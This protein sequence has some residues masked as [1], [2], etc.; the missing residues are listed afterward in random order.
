MNYVLEK[1][2][3]SELCTTIKLLEKRE[4]LSVCCWKYFCKRI[5]T[6]VLCKWVQVA[7]VWWAGRC[8]AERADDFLLLEPWNFPTQQNWYGWLASSHTGLS[9][10]RS[11][12]NEW[13]I[14]DLRAQIELLLR[15][16]I[17]PYGEKIFKGSIFSTFVVK[18]KGY[19]EPNVIAYRM[20]KSSV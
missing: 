11:I 7:N 13:R 15:T 8:W 1:K 19:S 14:V 3:H 6:F 4:K 2:K 16:V 20:I 17:V 18:N 9:T 12:A 10:W 5:N